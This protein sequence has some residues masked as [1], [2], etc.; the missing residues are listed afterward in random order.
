MLVIDAF[1]FGEKRVD[2]DALSEAAKD[3]LGAPL[4]GLEPESDAYP[5]VR[6]CSTWIERT[7]VFPAFVRV[8]GHPYITAVSYTH[9]DV[10]KRQHIF[11]SIVTN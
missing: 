9:L 7:A 5:P 3:M 6:S 2:Y 4:A 8:T 10:Y 1:F 11:N